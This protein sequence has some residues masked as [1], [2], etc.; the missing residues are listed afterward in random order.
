[1]ACDFLPVGVGESA[2]AENYAG[3]GTTAYLFKGADVDTS[4]LDVDE[5]KNKYIG[6]ALKEGAKIYPV[7]LKNQAN[8]VVGASLGKNKGFSNTGTLVVE[9]DLDV[10]AVCARTM[11]N[12]NFGILLLRP[13]IKAG[14]Y[15]LWNP[16]ADPTFELSDDT[17]DTF[18][19]DNQATWT[20]TS[21]PM[22]YPR[23]RISQED[24][25]A[26]EI[27]D[28]EESEDPGVTG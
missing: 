22:P 5:T 19:S 4:K 23:M 24:F 6:F 16:T 26:L 13:G 7:K 8:K 27:V 28:V 18:N 10:A 14:C 21:S 1:M 15:I 25:A 17:G 3:T 2:C 11:N 20:V 9:R 12:T